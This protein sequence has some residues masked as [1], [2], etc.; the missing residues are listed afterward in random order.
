MHD[1]LARMVEAVHTFNYEGTFVY[2]HDNHMETMKV[3]HAVRG[4]NEYERL[5][6]LNGTAREV[7]R[8]N[9]SVTCVAPD[10]KSVS[11]GKR[12]LGQGFRAI[13][14]ADTQ[15][16]T[17]NYEF[18]VL[19]ESRVAS[20]KAKVFAIIPKDNFRYGYRIHLDTETALPLKTDMLDS[21]GEA[22]SQLMFTSLRVDNSIESGTESLL[23]GKEH[24][25]WQQERPTRKLADKESQWYFGEQLPKGF[26]KFYHSRRPAPSGQPYTDHL[27]LSD[28][29]ATLSIYIEDG[30]AKN[31]LSG[32]SR[33]GAVNAFGIQISGFHATVVGEVPAVTVEVIAKSLK[34]SE[35]RQ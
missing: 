28:G 18:R 15:E 35:S 5:I 8:D 14:S 22:V 24:Y 26:K 19:G 9:A 23:E 20:R 32:T 21:Q 6:S 31:L 29:L 17:D 16:L 11:V 34:Y 10:S 4:D 33:M 7:I 2:L 3:I 25:S 30:A 1:W 13:F 27:V 12:L